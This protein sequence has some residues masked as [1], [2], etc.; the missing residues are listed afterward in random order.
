MPPPK[1]TTSEWADSERKLSP[2]SSAEP[3]QWRTS[4]VPYLREFMDVFDDPKVRELL[5]I[6]ASQTAKTEAVN[7]M[8][9]AR[10]TNYPGPMLL[11][12]PTLKM[13]KSWSKDRLAPMLRDTPCL[14][15]KVRSARTRDS[16]NTILHK[17]FDGGHL[18][19]VGANSAADLSMRPVRDV[20]C[21]EPDRY[22]PSAGTEGDPL[23]L[24][25]TRTRAFWDSKKAYIGSPTIRGASRM[26]LIWAR[27]DQRLYYVPCPDCGKHQTLKWSQVSWEKDEYGEHRPETAVYACEHCGSGWSD[28]QRR[29]AVKL[30]E[31]R[32][33]KPF[34][35]CAGFH[36]N[37]LAAPWESCNLEHLV[38]QWL[39]AQG[40]PELLKVF[41][42]TVLAE[43]WED[44]H[45]AKTVDETG[46]LARREPLPERDGRPEIPASCAILTA[47]GDLQENRGEISVYAWASGEE[48]WLLEHKVL[49]GDP[50]TAAFWQDVDAYL[51]APWPRAMGGVDYIRAAGIDSGYAT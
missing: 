7:N 51:I 9:G 17:A 13:A 35:R 43:W 25:V 3:G 37:A 49:F 42:N 40:N 6:F 14:R 28:L 18:T 24:V 31:W 5:G 45:Y 12:Q 34:R 26:E 20:F 22:P 10:V 47:F 21:D 29:Q 46:L 23:R 15:G 30:G 32:A 8:I 4:R 41:I 36:I 27:S 50:S 48:S 16:G 38:A 33:T 1:Q 19:V 11:M 2:E 44:A 39:E